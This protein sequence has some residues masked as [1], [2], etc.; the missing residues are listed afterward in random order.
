MPVRSPTPPH[1]PEGSSPSP[2]RLAHSEERAWARPHGTARRDQLFCVALGAVLLA[3][4]IAIQPSLTARRAT[5]VQEPE[6]ALKSLVINFPRLTLGGFR[7]LV[8]TV[9]WIQAEEDKDAHKW[10]S[11]ETKYD[12]IGAIEPYFVTIYVFHSWNQAYNLSAQWHEDDSK[13]KWILD[14]I[15]YL[16]KGEQYN[17]DN[18]DLILEEGH[19]YFLKLGSAFER[20]FFRAHWRADQAR[21]H[22]LNNLDPNDKSDSTE[23]LKQVRAFVNREEFNTQELPDP[24]GR[25]GRGYGL[26][27]TDSYLFDARKDGKASK[28]PMEF[29]YGVSP[30]YFGYVEFN[31]SL[32]AGVATTS[33][34]NVVNGWPPMCL[35]LWCRDDLYY[36]GDT[37][38]SLFYA[39]T[40]E[41]KEILGD[42]K[43]LNAK[44]V[45]VQD[46]YRNVDMIAPKSVDLFEKDIL[47]Y[48]SNE[49]VHRKHIYESKSYQ[50]IGRGG[51]QVIQ[52]PC[53]L[54]GRGPQVDGQGQEG[55]DRR[56]AWPY[57]DAISATETW[58]N[59]MYPIQEGKTVSPDRLDSERYENALKLR[60]SGIEAMIRSDP[61][62][63]P[64]M[65]FLE[66]EIVER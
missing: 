64:D 59:Y 2:M 12:I 44:I 40:D 7:G 16:Y 13:Y 28:D 42:L 17:P 56:I 10:Q 63:K 27:I 26:S 30:F 11:L 48:P 23:G 66:N 52:C 20:I 57:A 25:G 33:G 19:L 36:A 51:G 35:R 34:R 60:K 24:S 45:E 3:V 37:M 18:P 31:R 41:S 8:A 47:K 49:G 65:S 32:A 6:S 38:D 50:A 39:E 5:L 15:A 14:G 1:P 46:C 61:S 53:G 54:A 55:I 21:L 29:R 62:Q 4:A 58:V 43:K 9:L 22:D